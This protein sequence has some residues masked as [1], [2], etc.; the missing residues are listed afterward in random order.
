[1]TEKIA[2]RGFHIYREYGVDPLE[3][4]HVDEIKSSDVTSIA[5]DLSIGET[6][7]RYFGVDQKYRCYPVVDAD[8]RLCGMLDRASFHPLANPE[9]ALSTIFLPSDDH[10]P[11][12]FALPGETC[13]IAAARMASHHL[14]RLPVVSDS[15]SK[16]LIGIVSRS[17]LIKTYQ[18][19]FDEEQKRER[20]FDTQT[21]TENQ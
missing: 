9:V 21:V 14:E 6:L 15:Q 12:V 17:D 16:R 20:L 18:S 4:Q 13:R 7:T 2:R 10:H 1:M 5:S 8:Q 19:Y 11:L 3:R